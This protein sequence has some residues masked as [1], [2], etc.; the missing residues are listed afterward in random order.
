LLALTAS[1]VSVIPSQ[2]TVTTNGN[3]IVCSLGAIPGADSATL[4][5]VATPV[6]VGTMTNQ[7]T[8]SRAE[9][10]AYLPNN[11]AI[12]T[13]AVQT[14]TIA[15]NDVTLYEGNS[16][17]T[18]AVFTVSVSPPPALPVRVSFATVN[19]SAIAPADYI[20]TNGV[21]N[22]APGETN[23]S[24]VVRVIGDTAYESDEIFNVSLSSPSNAT[25]ADS[26][27]VGTILNDDPIPTLSIGDAT[28]AEG[29]SGATN[30]VFPVTLS[31]ASGLSVI[32][33]YAT[34]N[35]NA[36]AGSDYVAKS[37]S[38]TIPPGITSTNIT[39]SVNGDLL[40]EPDEVFYVDLSSPVNANLLKREGYGLILNDDGLPGQLDH[41]AWSILGPTQ[42]VGVPFSATI[43]ALDAF[44]NP[45]S[46]FV[47]NANLLASV[48][49]GLVTN[50]ILGNITYT[51][52]SSGAF[53][54]GYSFT[55]TTNLT[56]THVRSYFGTKVS[57]WNDSGALLAAQPVTGPLGL[58]TE[59]PLP[60]LLVLNAGTTYRVA[61]YSGGGPYYWRTDGLN[62][63]SNG[64]I[65][66][67]YNI[68]GD[69]FPTTSDA[70]R[71]W[72]VDLRFTVGSSV[73]SSLNPS[74]TGP[75]TNGA[76]TGNLA[77][78]LPATNLVV[79]ADDGNAHFGLSNPFNVEL[80]N[81]L[82]L[83]AADSPDPV[84]V[85]GYVTNLIT[86]TN[87]G[88][89]PATAV[90]VTNYLPGSVSFVSANSSQGA[91]ALVAGNVECALG[92]LAGSGSASIAVV[93]TP[94]SPGLITN[95]FAAGRGEF[96]PYPLNNSTSTVTTVIMPSLT[97]SDAVVLEGD[98]GQTNIS[99]AV[100]LSP[101][102]PLPVSVNFATAD[103]TA[104]AG[105]DYVAANGTLT[106]VYP[107][108]NKLIT[109]L[110][111]GDTNI[112]PS[113]TFAII[114]SSP[115]NATVART[116]AIGSIIN[117]DG[118]GLQTNYLASQIISNAL[119]PTVMTMAFD[120]ASY[121]DASGGT[122]SG[123]RLARYDL[124]GNLLNTY[125][126]G[127]D[128]RSVFADASGNLYARAYGSSIIYR[129]TSPGVF[130][131][132]LTL[133]GGSLDS[134]S[135]VVL[136]GDGT[137]F[138]ATLSGVVS[139]WLADGT[140]LGAVNLI[141]FGAVPG[142]TTFPQN[143]GIAAVGN[144]WLTYNGNGVISFWDTGGN[145]VWQAT[146][147]DTVATT[148]S[149]FTLSY[150]N[151]KVFVLDTT[152]GN[153]R[154]YDVCG[155]APPTAP[156]IYT[157][158]ADTTAP[159][160]GAA[161]FNVVA[162]GT[163]PLAYQW[164]QDTTNIL[165]ATSSSYTITSVQGNHLGTY[166]VFV[167]NP[168]GS[169]LS[170]NALLTFVPTPS[171]VLAQGNLWITLNLASGGITSVLFQS[172][173]VYQVGTFISDWGL[174][175]GTDPTTFVRNANGGAT[176]IGMTPV[177]G[178]SRTASFTGTYNAG[179]ASV[180]LT[181]DYALLLGADTL[182][183]TMT[184]VNN[185]VSS[186][187]MRYFETYD[188]DWIV[189]DNSYF[190][191]A[192]DRYTINTNGTSILLGRSIM[193]NGPLV[194]ILAT[195]DPAAIVAATSPSYF[196]IT[197]SSSLNTFFA[198]GGG[199]DGGALR[200]ATLDVGKD[201]FLA[202]GS[203]ATFVS[204]QSFGTNIASAEW[205]LVGNLAKAPLT[206]STPQQLPGGNLQLLAAA[207]DGSPITPERASHVQLYSST[208][209]SL[210]L[211]NWTPVTVETVLDNGAL[212]FNGLN[213]S[214]AP[215]RFFRAVE[216]P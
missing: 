207:S 125:A 36:T 88:P 86:V 77:A 78:L 141:G 40:V 99:F 206:F 57:I 10:D 155:Q 167:S 130:S 168:Y 118:C 122:S 19:G 131:N 22:F 195:V 87:S 174:Q 16:G 149:G 33:S 83:T 79:R 166:S 112:E 133:S 98:T 73:A 140:Y 91:C 102:S 176:S 75:F 63:F 85:G 129:Q 3:T 32:F 20:A 81:D 115:A 156:V 148:D 165:G 17:T 169:I 64:V 111:N 5:I 66:L 89:A 213:L 203:I 106:F 46:A 23:K 48:G 126:P 82:S 185:G 138:I 101:A 172:N 11:T 188:V 158:P 171:N 179:G 24:I 59:T 191:T 104:Q 74:V 42:Y 76:W 128:F 15:I 142:E 12:V 50:N 136:N 139:H 34:A 52:T 212:Q 117:D 110:V 27:G 93:T 1:L 184:F 121:W 194:V 68:S 37:G 144:Y 30:A 6:A 55:P 162:G 127:L 25:F 124:A 157:Q 49:G 47:G 28:L 209:A 145:R 103:I 61:A 178:D 26:I 199:D 69:A 123:T 45:A 39:V 7:T 38:I 132:Y 197:S 160:G 181:R 96:D 202:P 2:G 94:N 31:A 107:E 54:L 170:S 161:T 201:T 65:N 119:P 159:L 53:T 18:N 137:E 163:L 175:L 153:W 72:F 150:C 97:I 211:S 208:N 35:G 8:V 105:S 109:V 198:A 116:Q 177:S 120:G 146:L 21:L 143:R 71:W 108:T 187:T 216:L 193:T 84:V 204:Y 180:S 29:N 51:S 135:S 14:P 13:T 189:G 152:S 182:R 56:V 151:G 190:T 186:I 70:V 210:S 43:T 200:D 92:S 114:L 58:W 44:N 100:R 62:S 95:L 67:S 215:T 90:T 164:R 41:F 183:T 214:N 134:Q 192:N 60:T 196:G 113:E 147:Q 9:S 154:G 205:Y 80:R 173:E 4:N